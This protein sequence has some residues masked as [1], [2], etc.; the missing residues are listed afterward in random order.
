M[1]L[2]LEIAREFEIMP[3]CVG[4]ESYA[5]KALQAFIFGTHNP[6][7]ANFVTPFSNCYKKN[8]KFSQPNNIGDIEVTVLPL[9]HDINIQILL[10]FMTFRF[11]YTLYHIRIRN[12]GQ[13]L[14]KIS[15]RILLVY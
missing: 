13:L 2:F 1:R 5:N 15:F 7:D 4:F 9:L 8:W 3:F 12:C 6:N 10:N 11:P 14:T